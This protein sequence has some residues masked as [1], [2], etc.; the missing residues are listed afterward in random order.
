MCASPSNS[1]FNDG[2][3]ASWARVTFF[4]EDSSEIYVTSPLAFSVDIVTV[5]AAA[6]FDRQLEYI[7][8]FR[9]QLSQFG[10]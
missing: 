2:G 9:V 10:I 5:G 3:L 6:F 4:A 1:C 8:N 7:N